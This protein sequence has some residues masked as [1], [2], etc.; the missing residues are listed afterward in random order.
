[1]EML[2]Y[3]LA[4]WMNAFGTLAVLGIWIVATWR[5][6]FGDGPTFLIHSPGELAGTAIF[7][8]AGLT[9]PGLLWAILH[10]VQLRDEKLSRLLV[11]ALAYPAFLTRGL[12]ST[13]R[14]IGRHISKRQTWAKTERLAEE[15]LPA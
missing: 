11:A 5:L 4:P 13:W 12:I 6:I 14:A 15:P 8:L 9:V 1:L 2:Y 10:R 7:W 3:L